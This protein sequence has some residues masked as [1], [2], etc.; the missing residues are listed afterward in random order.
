[1]VGLNKAYL[2][3]EAFLSLNHNLEREKEYLLNR[4]EEYYNG[5]R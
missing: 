5:G 3:P 2:I 1:M 4:G